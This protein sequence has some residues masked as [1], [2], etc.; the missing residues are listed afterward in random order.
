M[1]TDTLNKKALRKQILQIRNNLTAEQI[2]IGGK[3]LC[4]KISDDVLFTSSRN[5]IAYASY[6]SE[7]YTYDFINMCLES[8]R[9]VFLPKVSGKDM[10][11]YKIFSEDDL[12]PGYRGIPEPIG[13]TE[14]YDYFNDNVNSPGSFML[15][16]GVVFDK[17]GHRIGYGGGFYDRY[18]C[19]KPKLLARSAAVCYDFQM[20]D[21]LPFE[22]HDIICNKI[23]CL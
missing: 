4:C 3:K 16:P 19:D 6:G 21:S 23:I 15:M 5:I 20:I 8:G 14:I 12:I 17:G 7:V 22:E 10:I 18:L 2:K 11:F 9:N 13:Y 1:E